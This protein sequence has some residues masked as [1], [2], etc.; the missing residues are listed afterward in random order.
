MV[1]QPYRP[2]R[3]VATSTWWR[4]CWRPRRMSML[5]LLYNGRT[6]L[7]AA[8]EGGHLDVVERLLA[9]KADVNAAAAYRGRTSPTGRGGRWPPRRG[10]EAAGG[11][12]GRQCCCC[13]WMVGRRYRP[14]REVA[15]STWWRGCW[16]PRRMSM[17]LLL[18]M[19][20]GRPYRPRREVA[21]STW[22]RGCWRPRRMSMLLLLVDGRTAL[23]AAAGGGHLDVVERLLAA[24]ADV[25]AAAAGGEWS[26]SPTGRGGRWSPRRGGEAVGGQGGCQCC[27]CLV[28]MVGQ[29]YRPRREVATSTW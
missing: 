15:I 28:Y 2:R 16:R 26:D 23:Q 24:K 18:W 11:Q 22:W 25:N 19:M 17:L 9:A 7:Q 10:R 4:G 3:K 14:R 13:C 29:P 20:V 1:G 12:G 8:A 6:A 21:T 27:C 5:L